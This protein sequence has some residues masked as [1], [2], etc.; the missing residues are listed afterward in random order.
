MG[1]MILSIDDCQVTSHKRDVLAV[2]FFNKVDDW[3]NLIKMGNDTMK[4]N[5]SKM[6]ILIVDDSSFSRN[7]IREILSA[8]GAQGS[9]LP[10]T[11]TLH[12]WW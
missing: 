6:I 2:L 4:E 3:N 7:M 5:N 10:R 11:A 1:L 9:Y 8:H 12:L